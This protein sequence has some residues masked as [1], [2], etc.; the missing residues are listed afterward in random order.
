MLLFFILSGFALVEQGMNA[1]DGMLQQ[2]WNEEEILREE[3]PGDHP[4]LSFG[5]SH[6]REG[7]S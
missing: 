5:S 6:P 2:R 7:V 1:L 3:A 4:K